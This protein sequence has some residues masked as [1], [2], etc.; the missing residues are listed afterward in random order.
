MAVTNCTLG[1]TRLLEKLA[2]RN[3]SE[4]SHS[5]TYYT[6]IDILYNLCHSNIYTLQYHR[7]TLGAPQQ[8]GVTDERHQAAEPVFSGR[9]H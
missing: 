9:D 8:P 1:Q 7:A 5:Y 2:G 6:A 3:L 4:Y